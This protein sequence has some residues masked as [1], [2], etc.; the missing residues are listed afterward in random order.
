MKQTSIKLQQT[1]IYIM[2]ITNTVQKPTFWDNV[3][4]HLWTA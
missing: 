3:S 2:N 4:K 1:H